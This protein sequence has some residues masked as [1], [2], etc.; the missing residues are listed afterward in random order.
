MNL[1]LLLTL[2]HLCF[3]RARPHTRKF[4][5]LS[6]YN[7]ESGRYGVGWDDAWFMM[8]WIVIFTGLRI[9]VMDYIMAPFADMAGIH[10]KKDKT[11]FAEQAWIY[12]YPCVFWSLGMVRRLSLRR[13][14]MTY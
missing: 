8:L 7:S 12:V 5:T 10:K 3:P 4:F 2:T 1:L 9:F 14:T 11:R 13:C 6:Y